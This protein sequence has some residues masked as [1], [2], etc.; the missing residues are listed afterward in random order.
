MGSLAH[1]L[2]TAGAQRT[3][4][5]VLFPFPLFEGRT[6]VEWEKSRF[7]VGRTQPRPGDWSCSLDREQGAGPEVLERG[8]C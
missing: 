2:H 3:L 1:V 4:V 6:M 8:K 7:E 5:P